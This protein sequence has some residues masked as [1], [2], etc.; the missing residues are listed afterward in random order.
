[1]PSHYNIS[2]SSY[3]N[4]PS[5]KTNNNIKTKL[6][7]KARFAIKNYISA[8]SGVNVAFKESHD[9]FLDLSPG[10]LSTRGRPPRESASEHSVML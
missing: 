7:N 6:G 8:Q 4:V 5:S 3:G 10:A 2:I 1:M 9:Y